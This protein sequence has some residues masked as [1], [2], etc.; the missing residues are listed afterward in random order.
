MELLKQIELKFKNIEAKLVKK[1]AATI[2][3][4][5]PQLELLNLRYDIAKL[6][7]KYAN[8]LNKQREE[9]LDQISSNMK[10]ELANVNEITPIN[11][12]KEV[13]S[14]LKRLNKKH[15]LKFQVKKINPKETCIQ[16]LI[17]KE[18]KFQRIFS[19]L[20]L[21]KYKKILGL[22][23]CI[24]MNYP[25]YDVVKFN[26]SFLEACIN[27]ISNLETLMLFVEAGADVNA[28]GQ[29]KK[30]ALILALRYVDFEKVK[31]LVENGADVNAKDNDNATALIEASEKGHFEIVKYL[32]QN[33]ADVDVKD[34]Y[35]NTALIIASFWGHFETVKYLVENGA[36]LDEKW[37]RTA[38]IFA[39]D[40][41]HFEIVKY[42]AE[43]GADV[44]ATNHSNRTALMDSSKNGQ[45]EVRI[46]YNQTRKRV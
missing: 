9:L 31:Y 11:D 33:G 29:N 17:K 23:N 30:T 40:K 19:A 44:N 35:N 18:Y 4:V 5:N 34:K 2:S 16:K 7:R 10:L 20:S 13:K 39:S 6:E 37:N 8:E 22:Q 46:V 41:G 38:L 1:I 45:K 27:G 12:A 26:D 25:S 28:K 43:N 42:L 36:D 24:S 21:I 15:R 3:S 32:H 14:S